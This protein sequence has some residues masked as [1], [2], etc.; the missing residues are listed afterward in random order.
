V[1]L[2]RGFLTKIAILIAVT[3]GSMVLAGWL[4]REHN[5]RLAARYG[6]E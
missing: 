3:L 2:R 5:L 1:G 4:S 6:D